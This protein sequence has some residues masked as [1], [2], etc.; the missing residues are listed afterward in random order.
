MGPCTLGCVGCQCVGCL[1]SQMPTTGPCTRSDGD[2]PYVCM[3]VMDP[4]CARTPWAPACVWCCAAMLSSKF[5]VAAVME[6]LLPGMPAGQMLPLPGMGWRGPLE[7]TASFKARKTPGISRV[8][9]S[10]CPVSPP[11]WD[12]MSRWMGEHHRSVVLP[13][14][15][16]FLW[17]FPV[18]QGLLCGAMHFQRAGARGKDMAPCHLQV[19]LPHVP[20][21]PPALRIWLCEATACLCG[22]AELFRQGAEESNKGQ[23]CL[24]RKKSHE[25]PDNKLYLQCALLIM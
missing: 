6:T 22:N 21:W 16:T 9:E 8:S 3:A 5:R 2:G 12:M 7:F 1:H 13:R 11:L 14:A 17:C 19:T 20:A 15:A 10:T 18:L 24:C 4:V 25:R 23:H